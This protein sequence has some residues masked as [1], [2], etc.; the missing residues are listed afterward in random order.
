MGKELSFILAKKGYKVRVFDIPQANF[1]GLKEKDIEIFEGDITDKASVKKSL[2]DV[3]TVVH[4]AAILPPLSE[5]NK[6]LAFK[7]NVDGTKNL[8][9][10]I[11][12]KYKLQR[13]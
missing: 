7:V 3:D 5:N 10:A 6:E 11:E 1:T 8:V 2:K 9:N 13:I 4:L 12:S